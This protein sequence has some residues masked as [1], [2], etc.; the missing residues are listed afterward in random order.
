MKAKL[1]FL[2]L[3]LFLSLPFFAHSTHIVGGSLT[4]VHNGG[5]NYTVTLKL[6]RDCGPGTVQLP[7][8]VTISVLGYNGAAFS[9]SRDITIPLSTI[10]PVPSNLDTCATPPNPMP[11][12]QEG[13]YTITVNNLPPNPGGYHMYFQVVARNLSLTNVNASGNNVGESFYAYIPGPAVLWGEDFALANG[14]TVDNGTT[15]WSTTAGAIAPTTASVN[16]NLFQ[17][18]GDDD[19]QQTWTSQVIPIAAFIGGVN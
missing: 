9:P 14:T 19:G 1:H 8:S 13:L 3:T 16:N 11:C 4:Y 2:L 7:N 15:A 6:Y 10:T 12:T 18:T 17:L 5:S